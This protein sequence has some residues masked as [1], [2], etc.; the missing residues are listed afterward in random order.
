MKAILKLTLLGAAFA[1]LNL[2]A[3]AGPGPQDFPRRVATKAEAMECHKAGAK[4][5]LACKG[6]KTADAKSDETSIADLF[7]PGST[8]GCDGCKGKI[9]VKEAGKGAVKG[10][11]VH[12]CS[13]CG[14]DSAYTCSDHKK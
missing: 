4:V 1:S 7:K 10:A 9:T 14:A 3:L 2:V 5:A 13:K 6:C 12:E 11:V 8:H